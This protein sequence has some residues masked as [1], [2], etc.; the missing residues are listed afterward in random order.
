MCMSYK[1]YKYGKILDDKASFCDR[2]DTNRIKV[3]S[4]KNK[5]ETVN[6]RSYLIYIIY[7]RVL[8]L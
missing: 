3:A 1:C 6:K 4:N 7:S 8:Y 5:N 2:Y